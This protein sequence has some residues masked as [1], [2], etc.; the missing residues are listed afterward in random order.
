MSEH[1]TSTVSK[2]K[3][4]ALVAIVIIVTLVIGGYHFRNSKV[5]VDATTH[6]PE[7]YTELYFNNP[8]HLPTAIGIGQQ[9]SVGFVTHNLEARSM[10][11]PYTL[12]LMTDNGKILVEKQADFT[13][14]SGNTKT[15]TN[16]ISVPISYQGKAEV[17][18]AFTKLNQSIDYWIEIR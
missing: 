12:A 15:T 11:Y 5:F 7:R 4:I 10:T 1:R 8:T 3:A 18:V 13:L 14:P 2:P 9:L 6:Q 16:T 17:Q